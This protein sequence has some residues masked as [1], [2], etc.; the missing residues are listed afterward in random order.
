M[1]TKKLN[2]AQTIRILKNNDGWYLQ[3]DYGAIIYSDDGDDMYEISNRVLQRLINLNI[4]EF[5]GNGTCFWN[6]K[7]YKLVKNGK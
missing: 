3:G 6:S 5:C 4:I 2:S 7:Y 1:Q